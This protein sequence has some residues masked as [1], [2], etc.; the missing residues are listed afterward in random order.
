MDKLRVADAITEDF[1]MSSNAAINTLTKQCRGRLQKTK[2]R[3]TVLRQY[4][5]IL[6]VEHFRAEQNFSQ[7]FMPE[8]AEKILAQLNRR[9]TLR[10]SVLSIRNRTENLDPYL[11][12]VILQ[13][14]W[15][16]VAK[17]HPAEAEE[18]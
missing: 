4:F 9:K 7:S 2:R 5:I 10:H 12:A 14:S 1:H 18:A 17:L 13:K 6:I 8:T 15:Q 11:H 3:K 16:E